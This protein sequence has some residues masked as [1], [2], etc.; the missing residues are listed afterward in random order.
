MPSWSRA[1][2]RLLLRVSLALGVP[3]VQHAGGHAFPLAQ[4]A[5]Q[6]VLGADVVVAHL[7]RLVDGQL[8][9]FLGAGGEAGLAG[10]RF[11]TAPDDELHR[12]AHLAQ[13]DAQVGQDP[14][15]DSLVLA[16]QTE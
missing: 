11:L 8:D 4:Q 16:Y 2:V 7:A 15:G 14:G 1:G 12:R 10:A 5:Q 13:A 6:Q 9:D 3:W